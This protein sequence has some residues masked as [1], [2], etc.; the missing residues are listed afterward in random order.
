MRRII[1]IFIFSMVF[2]SCFLNTTSQNALKPLKSIKLNIIEPSGVSFYNNH[3]YIVSD[4]NGLVYKT[5]L[6]GEIL[7]KIQVSYTNN[8]GV[9]FNSKGNLVVV[10]EPKRRLIEIDSTLKKEK[11]FRI[12][13][14]Q[15]HNNSGLEGVCFV[16][17]EDS[18][19]IVNEKSPKQILKVSKKGKIKK[20]IRIKFADDLSGICFDKDLN[21]LWIVSDE[22]RTIMNVSLSGKLLKSYP[23]PV[24]KAEGI[25][26]KGNQIFIVS[27]QENSLYIFEKPN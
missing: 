22:S 5:D 25:T 20:E 4:Y 12:K 27:D 14:K 26:I 1:H 10:N 2:S 11:K 23:I 17:M 13:G 3:L 7:E 9:C 18:Y 19:F 6:N 21:S 24:L 16:P 15:K 8:E